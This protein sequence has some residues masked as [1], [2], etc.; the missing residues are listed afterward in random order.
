MLAVTTLSAERVQWQDQ[1]LYPTGRQKA[2]ALM[3]FLAVEWS[4]FERTTHRRE[5]LADLLWPD[6]DRTDGLNN[7]RQSLHIIR[8][9]CRAAGIPPIFAAD[10]QKVYRQEGLSIWCDL[11]NLL[12]VTTPGLLHLPKG[13]LAVL[14]N[15]VLYDAYPF[16]EWL[17]G[18]RASV[19]KAA[20]RAFEKAIDRE[21]ERQQWAVAA[22]LMHYQLDWGQAT[23]DL[24]EKLARACV[25]QGK[26]GEAEHWLAQTGRSVEYCRQQLRGWEQEIYSMAPAES[27][28]PAP[29]AMTWYLL[30]WSIFV[31]ATP[32]TTNQAVA[33]FQRAIQADPNF[34]RAY[35]GLATA[36]ST[37][38]SWWGDRRMIDELPAFEAAVAQ[39][40]KDPALDPEVDAV[41]GFTKMWL[42]ELEEAEA[43]LRRAMHVT[44]S[45]SFGLMGLSHALNVQGKWDEA[46]AIT[47]R[48]ILK[49][50][51]FI[52]SYICLGETAI[53]EGDPEAGC[54]ICQAALAREPD[55]QPGITTWMWGL[56]ELGRCEEAIQ[57]G[58]TILYR[59]GWRSFFVV[60][61][62]AMAYYAAGQ[63][64][65]AGQLLEEMETRARA[66]EKGFPY[67]IALYHMRA[68]NA[69]A[70]LDWLERH[71]PNRHT[72]YLW[73][74]VQPEFRALRGNPRFDRI[75]QV[76]FG[77][78]EVRSAM[79]GRDS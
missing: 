41:V 58:E 10:R 49:D 34:Y 32:A 57:V 60:G 18:L 42:W 28:V 24:Y 1:D 43:Y 21:L 73:L 26:F 65:R 30:G 39:A 29:Q 64:A 3:L 52:Q 46:R 50:P 20:A 6:L 45:T 72:D 15:L 47:Q 38:G 69:D 14:P 77:T 23:T 71:L 31:K 40:R 78:A 70:A 35:L 2:D 79:R 36:I 25:H 55:Y 16:Q 53:L 66:G 74:D 67:F 4:F 9:R 5:W 33:H 63:T 76:V 75:W 27:H 56:L 48:A 17:D 19:N 62:L 22:D 37:Q 51:H 13:N 59:T 8:K 44:S 54:E 7:L 61:R 68:G 11:Q 12:T